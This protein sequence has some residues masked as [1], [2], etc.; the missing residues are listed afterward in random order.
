MMKMLVLFLKVTK[1]FIIDGIFNTKTSIKLKYFTIVKKIREYIKQHD[2][3]V[4]VGVDTVQA[5]FDFACY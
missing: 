3:D 1:I 4:L 5:L 2:I